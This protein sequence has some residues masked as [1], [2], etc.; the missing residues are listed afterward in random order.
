VAFLST[1]LKAQASYALYRGVLTVL[2]AFAKVAKYL[3]HFTS[4]GLLACDA[5]RKRQQQGEAER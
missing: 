4:P 5:A 3:L 1:A 2:R